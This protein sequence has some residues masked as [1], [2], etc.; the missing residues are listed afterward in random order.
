MIGSLFLLEADTKDEVVAFNQA[1]PF[2]AAGVW[3]SVNI[4][5]FAKRVDN[6]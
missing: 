2:N 3:A 5:P 4:H 6:R 1:D